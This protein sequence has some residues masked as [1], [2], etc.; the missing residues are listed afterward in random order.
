MKQE[1][2]NHQ[3]GS[4]STIKMKVKL[5]VAKNRNLTSEF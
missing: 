2:G 5:K 1:T 4:E 3:K